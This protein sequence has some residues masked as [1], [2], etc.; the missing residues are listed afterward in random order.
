MGWYM[1]A[2]VDTIDILPDSDPRR[3]TL[4]AILSRLAAAVTKYQDPA[5]GLWYQ[6]PIARKQRTIMSSPPPP[7]CSSTRWARACASATS[8]RTT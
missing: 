1:M 6:V 4:I 8:R 2:L 7:A 3:A 5:T